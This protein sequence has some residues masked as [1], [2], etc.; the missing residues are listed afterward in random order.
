MIT[1][2]TLG[3]ILFTLFTLSASKV[4]QAADNG[5]GVT[6]INYTLDTTTNDVNLGYTITINASVTNYD[7]TPFRGVLNFGLHNNILELSNSGIFDKPPYS[8]DSI[9]LGG[10]ETVP[11]IFSIDINTP[12][13]MPGPDVIVVWPISPAPIADSI[14]I[15]LNIIGPNS[16]HGPQEIPFTYTLVNNTIALK[17]SDAKI[18]FKQVRI[19]NSIGQKILELNTDFIS[20]IPLPSLSAGIYFCQL[21]TDNGKMATIKFVETGK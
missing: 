19:Y 1:R 11:A 18:D 7:S 15:H 16:I 9:S 20:S 17:T 21:I 8:G 10:H 3:I 6:L 14:L 2:Q 4:I 13:F 12:Y 5:V